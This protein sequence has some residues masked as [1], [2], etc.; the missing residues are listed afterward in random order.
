MLE[1]RVARS[2]VATRGGVYL[3]MSYGDLPR[4]AVQKLRS[5]EAPDRKSVV[6]LGWRRPASW[7][8][9]ASR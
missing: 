8:T 6:Q 3:P 9:S 2:N 7:D 1:M 5:Q 4:I